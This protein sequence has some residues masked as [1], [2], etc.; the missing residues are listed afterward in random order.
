MSA[1]QPHHHEHQHEHAHAHPRGVR[2]FLHE[3]FVPHTHDAADA[4]D[5]ALTSHRAGVRALQLSLAI[6]LAT[7]LA[8]AIIVSFTG[9]VAL[10]ADTI[11]NLSDALTAVPLWIAFAL[12]RRRPTR[13]YT[14]GL[15]RAEDL[16]GLAIVLA[17]AASAVVA[18][19]QA[20][21]RIIDPR[22][23][24]HV[25]WVMAAGIVGFLGNE[26][27]AIYRIRVG[28][29]IG[30]AALVADGVHARADGVTSLAV[31]LGGVGVLLG[32]PLADPI[33]GL[34]I[35]VFIVALLVG[36]V[37]SVGRRLLDG[38]DPALVTRA[39][40]ALAHVAEV[41]AVERVRIRW[42]GHRLHGDA[43]V[44]ADVTDLADADR[45]RAEAERSV[46]EHLAHVE[47][48]DVHVHP[49]EVAR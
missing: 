20:I 13:T 36:T 26:A 41:R 23:I 40:H 27:V 29:Q 48:F 43:I 4:I 24:D 32:F 2:G 31:V 34:L 47:E 46:R 38:I 6:M 7:T 8:Q 25:G 39:E 49:G 42:V 37:R 1:A 30:S 14:Y 33:V 10:L 3:V 21:E 5:D 12:A 17:I 18:A 28:R 16:A 44:R 11:H 9:S 45:I 19:W 35:A 15:G 22:P